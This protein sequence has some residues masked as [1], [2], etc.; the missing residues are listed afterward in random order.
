VTLSH[1]PFCVVSSREEKRKENINNDSV[2]LPS[3]D[4]IEKAF[5]AL[6][7]I[8]EALEVVNTILLSV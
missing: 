2:V 1:T 5:L 3:H 7:F 8:S 6:V 4:M